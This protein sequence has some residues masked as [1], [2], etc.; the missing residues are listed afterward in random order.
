ML[1]RRSRVRG[2]CETLPTVT[3][4]RRV[5]A[6][7]GRVSVAI[8]AMRMASGDP[9]VLLVE[10]DDELSRLIADYLDHNGLQVYVESDGAAAL[11]AVKR[12]SPDLVILDQMLPRSEER[13]VGKESRSRW[14]PYQ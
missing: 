10:D 5:P 3:F 6:G 1:G 13:R 8:V 9:R 12:W 7:L 2:R 4:P 14:S 11:A